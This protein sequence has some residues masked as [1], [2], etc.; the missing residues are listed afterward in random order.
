MLV[1]PRTEVG[2][3]TVQIILWYPPEPVRAGPGSNL[4]WARLQNP[5]AHVR[6]KSRGRLGWAMSQHS[7]AHAKV[8]AG[9]RPGWARPQHP[10]QVLGL[11]VDHVRPGCSAGHDV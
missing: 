6:T 8:G 9:N 2:G 1:C 5:P 7:P 10:Q 4:G 3:G 11:G